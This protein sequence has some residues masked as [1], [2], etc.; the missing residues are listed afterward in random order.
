MKRKPGESR[1]DFKHRMFKVRSSQ[2]LQN[3]RNRSRKYNLPLPSYS[4]DELRVKLIAALLTPCLGCGEKITPKNMSADHAIPLSRGGQ[5]EFDNLIVICTRCNKTKNKLT[6][7]EFS[8]LVS[9]LSGWDP[10]A[11][12]DVMMRLSLAGNMLPRLFG[13]KK[14]TK[15]SIEIEAA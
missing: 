11:K 6:F 12:R 15:P 2:M 14:E 5:P 8:Q 10:V 3:H 9:L 7:S 1:D 13:K 4:L